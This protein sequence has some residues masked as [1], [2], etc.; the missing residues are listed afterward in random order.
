MA[1]NEGANGMRDGRKAAVLSLHFSPAFISHMIAYG[2]SLRELGYEVTFLLDERYLS[3]GSFSAV[4]MVTG[5]KEYIARASQKFDVAIFCNSSPRNPFFTSRMRAQGTAVLYVY[6]EPISVWDWRQLRL[7][8]WRQIARFPFSAYFSIRTLRQSSGVIVPSACARVDYDRNY[9]KYNSNVHTL[10]LL[11]DD[12]I[13]A[14]QF[15]EAVGHK[16]LFGFI[17]NVSRGH[18]FDRFVAFAKYAI[19]NGS[20]IPFVIAT[21]QNLGKLLSDDE[22]FRYVR[23]GKI[24]I[25]HGRVLS[26]DEINQYYLQCFCVWNVY[27]RSTQSGVM[28]RSFMA[29]TPVLASRL[30]SF[31][32]YVRE[33][34]TGEFVDSGDD[35]PSL[36]SIV[37]NMRSQY[38]KYVEGCRRMFLEKFYYKANIDRLAS[39]INELR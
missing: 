31:P 37:E 19:K 18:G 38:S 8:G 5:A 26:N 22:F 29:G 11:Y 15:N 1:I 24:R 25:E 10:P 6:H 9:Q 17:G 33:G 21:R 2:K 23:D 35:L 3:F 4:G 14:E 7:E 16:R 39:I 34:V 30:G 28:P 27:R 13:N 20:V 32:E 36:L 12:E